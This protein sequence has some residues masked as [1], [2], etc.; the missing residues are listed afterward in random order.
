M[1]V[2]EIVYWNLKCYS[3]EL[4]QSIVS[5]WDIVQLLVLMRRVDEKF[6]ITEEFMGLV[7]L[8]KK[9]TGTAGLEYKLP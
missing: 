7:P 8:K 2:T 9:T 3:L 6:L 5:R 4:D 1:T